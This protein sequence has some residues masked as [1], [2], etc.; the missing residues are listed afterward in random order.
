M[1]VLDAGYVKEFDSPHQLLQRENG[2]FCAMVDAMGQNESANIRQLVSLI[3]TKTSELVTVVLYIHCRQEKLTETLD[4]L[5]RIRDSNNHLRDPLFDY[6]GLVT[7]SGLR[8]NL[9]LHR[10][11]QGLWLNPHSLKRGL[12]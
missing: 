8:N 1:Q 7:K 5:G 4:Q 6:N 3:R 10:P 2:L 12:L 9:I 11:T